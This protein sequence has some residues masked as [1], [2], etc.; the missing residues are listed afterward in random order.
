MAVPSKYGPEEAAERAHR[1]I[2]SRIQQNLKENKTMVPLYEALLKD[3]KR[4]D[5]LKSKNK[6]IPREL[7]KNRYYIEYYAAKGMLE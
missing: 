4:I 6:K 3:Q 1:R 5:E 7:I 2:A